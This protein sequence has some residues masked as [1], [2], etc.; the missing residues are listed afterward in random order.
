MSCPVCGGRT[1]ANNEC[2]KRCVRPADPMPGWATTTPLASEA[3]V[4]PW[5]TMPTLVFEDGTISIRLSGYGAENGGGIFTFDE[6]TVRWH[7]HD[8]RSG[9]YLTVEI[10]KSEMIEL[11]DWLTDQLKKVTPSATVEGAT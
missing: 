11:R 4:Q 2:A 8:N 1:N 3:T 9:S 7:E 6:T 10:A 5:K